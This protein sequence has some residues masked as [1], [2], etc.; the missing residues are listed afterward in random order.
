MPCTFMAQNKDDA[1]QQ[2]RDMQMVMLMKQIEL[3][4]RL[5][6]LKMKMSNRM[7]GGGLE[8]HCLMA[9]NTPMD[10]L[11][12]LNLDLDSMMSEVRATNP[13]I[14]NVLANSAKAM[15]LDSAAQVLG[16]PK[17]DEDD[18]DNGEIVKDLL[19]DG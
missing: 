13:I 1:N 11:E 18:K 7:G 9:F 15:G 4:E 5:I 12:K 17:C 10:K 6:E 3:T 14:G 16:M 2:H 8:A 19:M